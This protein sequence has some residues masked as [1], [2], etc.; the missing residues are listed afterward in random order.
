MP[1][2]P[3]RRDF[4]R[5]SAATGGGLLLPSL[6]GTAAP[7]DT[8]RSGKRIRVLVWDEQQ[9]A[10]KEAY[11]NFLGNWLAGYLAARPGLS[12]KSARLDDPEQGLSDDALGSCDVLLWWGHQRQAEVTPET[13]KKLVERI[14]AGTLALI[15]L[16]SAHWSTPFVEAMNERT[17]ADAERTLHGD[18]KEKVEISYVEPPRR[19]TQPKADER[20]TP[21]AALRKFPD[22]VTWAAVH[23]PYC[24][25]PE[26]RT[27]GK[28]SQIRVLVPKHPITQGLPEQFELPHTEMYNEPFHVPEPDEV[29]LEERWAGGEWFRSGMVWKVGAGRVFYFRPGHETFAVY[30]EKPTLLLLENAVRWLADRSR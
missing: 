21:Y 13:G 25:F 19:Y 22:G 29:V 30:K 28:S 24:C 23:L 14:K 12:V 17:R 27:D 11:D 15:A 4:L 26:Y 7:A 9:P 3:S 8:P 20:G 1:D 10:Q 5:A 6:A 18:T 2:A 16:H